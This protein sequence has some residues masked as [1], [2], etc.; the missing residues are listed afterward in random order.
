MMSSP[1]L[2]IAGIA[3]PRESYLDLQQT[4]EPVDGGN[5][6]RRM[7]NGALFN[8][9]RWRRWRT[10]ISAS[11]WTPSPLLSINYDMP[12]EVHCCQPLA[13]LPGESLPPSWQLRTDFVGG[14]VVHRGGVTTRLVYPIL[15]V[16]ATPPRLI[17]GASPSWELSCEEV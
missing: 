3:L 12:F 9:T 16:M 17:P 2:I 5:S 13:L 4:F 14:E 7:G 11:G 1:T 10:S 8:S 6:R 15:T